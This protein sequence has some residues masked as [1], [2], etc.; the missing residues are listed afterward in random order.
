ME[1]EPL[2]EATPAKSTPVE[3]T[4]GATPTEGRN[5]D[6]SPRE[7]THGEALPAGR[8]PEEVM[9]DASIGRRL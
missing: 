3:A 4:L 1:V 6:A 2:G 8:E 7:G 9:P 5:D